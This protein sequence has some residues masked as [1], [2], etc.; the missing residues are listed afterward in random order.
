MFHDIY[1][2][3]R[4]TNTRRQWLKFN[5]S[6]VIS[7]GFEIYIPLNFQSAIGQNSTKFNEILDPT[8]MK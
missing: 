8:I 5:E 3:E 1:V 4:E 7:V 2:F 6:L